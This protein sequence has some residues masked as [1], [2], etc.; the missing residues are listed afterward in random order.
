VDGGGASYG[1]RGGSVSCGGSDG[2]SEAVGTAKWWRPLSKCWWLG[3]APLFG[4]GH[5]PVSTVRFQ[6]FFPICP[7]L[8][9][10]V[11]SKWMPYLANRNK[12]KNPG[13][14]F[15][16]C[17]LQIPN[18]NKIKNPGTDSIFESLMN[19]KRDSNL[20]QKSDKFSKIPS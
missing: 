1:W 16:L 6:F 11:K 12:V 2:D 20:L 14:L 19:F 4:Q 10:H 15:K 3:W 8:A 13:Q 17:G 18:R 7:K 9:Q 5:R